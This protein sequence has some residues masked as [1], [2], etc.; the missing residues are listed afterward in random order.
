MSNVANCM[1]INRVEFGLQLLTAIL[2][3]FAA[4]FVSLQLS[5]RFG[6]PVDNFDALTGVARS[7]QWQV[8]R[9]VE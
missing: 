2:I 8:P 6:V 3:T 5:V 4:G 1:A 9:R 7:I